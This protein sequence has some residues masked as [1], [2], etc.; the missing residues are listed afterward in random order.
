MNHVDK[1]GYLNTDFLLFHLT[2]KTEEEMKFHYHEFDKIVVLLDGRATYSVEGREYFLQ[3][4]DILLVRHHDIHKPIMDREYGYERIVIW[5]NHD[6]LV[7][8]SSSD[9]DLALAFTLLSKNSNC[10]LRPSEDD[11]K[12][13]MDKLFELEEYAGSTAYG[14]ALLKSSALIQFLVLTSR[15]AIRGTEYEA[16]S[17]CRYD[18]KIDAIIKYINSNL[19]TAPDCDEIAA[20]FF[21][22][23]SYLMHKF[24]SETGYT[25][26]NY[27]LQKRLLYSRSLI[28]QGHTINEAA[29]AS[30]F[31]EYTTYL[32]AFKKLFG[33]LPSD[34]S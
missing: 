31:T 10:L 32:R 26:H 13:C 1:R 22:S 17:V 11:R 33:A 29:L 18:T 27:C 24:K 23:K 30:G 6:F 5:I 2:D 4:G 7:N 19:D 15:L 8:N 3:P 34:F 9:T 20:R 25:I 14:S 16:S 28:E 21:I 12:I